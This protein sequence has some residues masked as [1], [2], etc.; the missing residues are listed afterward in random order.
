M[1]NFT[2]SNATINSATA[3]ASYNTGVVVGSFLFLERSIYFHF[4]KYIFVQPKIDQNQNTNNNYQPP[5]SLLGRHCT[6]IWLDHVGYLHSWRI[7]EWP[8]YFGILQWS[9]QVDWRTAN[10][11][12]V[13]RFRLASQFIRYISLVK[14]AWHHSN[15]QWIMKK[16]STNLF[17]HQRGHL[18]RHCPARTST[19]VLPMVLWFGHRDSVSLHVWS[20][21]LRPRIC[22]LGSIVGHVFPF[23][24]FQMES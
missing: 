5:Q 3:V 21:S 4:T 17:R 23:A 8:N 7:P 6:A 20:V 16:Y 15:I 1:D 9:Y 2:I 10:A 18:V 11:S 14:H 19:I 22:V 13:G 24:L 12:Y